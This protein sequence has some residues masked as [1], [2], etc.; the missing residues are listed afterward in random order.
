MTSHNGIDLDQVTQFTRLLTADPTAAQTSLRTHHRWDGSYLV[1]ATGDELRLAG[2]VLP[3]SH[4]VISDRPVA[5]AGGDRGPVPGELVLAA[6]AACITG[7]FVE[8]AA[9][10]AV[11]LESV[12]LACEAH[13]DLR[14]SLGIGEVQPGLQRVAVL[15]E[16]ASSAEAQVLDDLLA[17]AV[18]T[19]PVAA[20][21]S[22]RVELTCTL[23]VREREPMPG[24]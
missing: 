1:T 24:R 4:I 18:S 5:F 2:A 13:L 8:Q 20:S 23:Q 6:L 12:D 14:G 19:S 3:R 21:L 17:R 22:D 10:R 9:V 16:V 7:Q 11:A 15:A